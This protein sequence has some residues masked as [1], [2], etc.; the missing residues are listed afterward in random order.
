MAACS[1]ELA[2]AD[3]KS[4]G[5]TGGDGGMAGVLGGSAGSTKTGG[6]AGIP[7]TGGVA[8][9][10]ALGGSA[11]SDAALGGSGGSTPDASVQPGPLIGNFT[12]SYYWVTTEEE[13]TGTKNTNLY[14]S[15]CK[16]LA[17]V[18]ATFAASLAS[19][20][21]GRLSDGRVLN[22]AGSCSCPT[23]P[24]Y[25]E[26]DAQHPWGYGVQNAALVPFRTLAV[27]KTEIPYGTSLY[28][29]ALVG[30]KMPGTPPWG[31]FVHDGCLSADD[32]GSSL[33]ALHADWFVALKAHYATLD[34]ALDLAPTAVHDGGSLCP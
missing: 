12:I 1:V 6:S 32:T 4:P 29:P 19:I 16:I 10:V 24:C 31:G 7:S 8:G 2:P 27:Q 20:G 3:D 15:G 22:Y 34:P 13:F 5:T 9:S 11:G 28:A 30:V 21:T 26:A 14:D 23:T 33:Q 18:S 25:L 17:T